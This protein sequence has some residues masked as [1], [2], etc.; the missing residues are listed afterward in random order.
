MALLQN[1]LEKLM[2]KY[3]FLIVGAG[4]FGAT[5]AN[6][7]KS[8]GKKC[9][10]I[11]KRKHIGGNCYTENK[12]GIQ[13]HRYGAHIFHT[14]NKEVWNYINKFAEFNNYINQPIAIVRDKTYNLPFNM[15]L[16]S[17]VFDVTTP[18]QAKEK[19]NN[20]ILEYKDLIPNNLEEQAIKMVGKTIYEMFIKGYTQKQWGKDC[21]NL[22]V[23]TIKRLP[24]RFTYDNNYFDDLYQGIPKL[25][26]TQMIDNMLSKIDVRLNTSYLHSEIQSDKVIYTGQ[27]DEFFEYKLGALE[28]RTLNFEDK[29]FDSTNYQGNAVINYPTLEKLYTRTIE[30]RHFNRDTMSDKTVISYEYSNTFIP[31]LGLTP[32]YPIGNKENIDLYNKYKKLS[33]DFPNVHFAGRLGE[34]KYYDMDDTIE[35]AIE[36]TNKII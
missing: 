14:N 18:E 20:E 31:S 30:H 17:K 3:D 13:I 35:S 21:K 33:K 24:L 6:I 8:K 19:I 11:D 5:F 23:D 26:Y 2:Q 32:Y 15:N 25:G 16:F 7:A 4:L 9:L 10:V 36:L 28:Y 1:L 29:W 34:Y 27:I 22:P 12:E